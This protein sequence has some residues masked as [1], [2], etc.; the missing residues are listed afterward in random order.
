MRGASPGFFA[1]RVLPLGMAASKC[2]CCRDWFGI[3]RAGCPR[4]SRPDAGVTLRS[5]APLDSRA[6]LSPRRLG[7]SGCR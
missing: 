3:A 2:G 4:D 6:R 5:F 1:R 7:R